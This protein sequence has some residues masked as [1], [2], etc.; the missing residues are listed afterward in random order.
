MRARLG[1]SPRRVPSAHGRLPRPLGGGGVRGSSTSER[2]RLAP[3]AARVAR[4][5]VARAIVHR[6]CDD[7]HCGT[8]TRRRGARARAACCAPTGAARPR[9]RR[10]RRPRAAA[11]RGRALSA[12][13]PRARRAAARRP[14]RGLEARRRA[15]AR[16]AR[17]A[18]WSRSRCEHARARTGHVEPPGL[19]RTL[20]SAGLHA[21]SRVGV[22]ARLR[23]L[24]GRVC[25][26]GRSAIVK[27]PH[28]DRRRT[29][30]VRP[31]RSWTSAWSVGAGV[32]SK[33]DSMRSNTTAAIAVALPPVASSLSAPASAARTIAACPFSAAMNSRVQPSFVASS[34]SA[35]AS[36]SARTTAPCPYT[37]AMCS[38]VAS[39]FFATSLSARRRA[40]RHDRGVPVPGGHVQRGGAATARAPCRRRRRAARARS[41]AP[42]GRDIQRGGTVVG[43]EVLVGAGSAG[44]STRASPC[45]VAMNSGVVPS[46]S[47]R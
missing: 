19:S 10:R 5:Q 3:C 7:V 47:V 6:L 27:R 17:R 44:R 46:C 40:A 24:R 18:C 34:L 39:S 20:S 31:S 28:L 11:P 14:H 42:A 41:S 35:P 13:W 4:G 23:A 9:P 8:A 38:G 12:A 21:A 37:A 1:R 29:A 25:P 45:T 43:R 22:C 16:S 36:S 32:A 2:L 15:A 26:H 33:K 30:A